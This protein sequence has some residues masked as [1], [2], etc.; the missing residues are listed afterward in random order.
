MHMGQSL[1]FSKIPPLSEAEIDQFGYKLADLWMVHHQKKIYGPYFIDDLQKV[2]FNHTTKL[3]PSSACNLER[4]RWFFFFDNAAFQHRNDQTFYKPLV[5]TTEELLIYAGEKEHGPYTFPELVHHLKNKKFKYVDLFSINKGESW[6]KIYEIDGLDRRKEDNDQL[7]LPDIPEMSAYTPEQLKFMKRTPKNHNVILELKK[8]D[9]TA[10][11]KT[12]RERPTNKRTQARVQQVKRKSENSSFSFIILIILIAFVGWFFR[13][14]IQEFIAPNTKTSMDINGRFYQ[15]SVSKY[16]LALTASKGGKPRI[17]VKDSEESLSLKMKKVEQQ[18][19]EIAEALPVEEETTTAFAEQESEEETLAEESDSV[20][21]SNDF[22]S[23]PE[24][25]TTFLSAN[26]DAPSLEPVEDMAYG[27]NDFSDSSGGFV[28]DEGG[29][30]P[31][32]TYASD[33]DTVYDRNQDYFEPDDQGYSNAPPTETFVPEGG[34]Y[35]SETYI[36]EY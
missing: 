17:H 21:V 29:T 4:G 14:K 25:E 3:E 26:N 24:V 20:V 22:M 9:P 33:P 10:A 36:D 6:R 18:E 7:K 35:P 23:A 5:V 8:I 27:E 34:D 2:A 1:D 11:P 32:D 16:N 31:L 15:R 13:A 12:K 28:P 19:E 30:A